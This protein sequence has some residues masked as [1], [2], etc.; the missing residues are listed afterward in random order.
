MP[1]KPCAKQTPPY[2]FPRWVLHPEPYGYNTPD[3]DEPYADQ[4][5]TIARFF[6]KEMCDELVASFG[7][8]AMD[9]TP[10]VKSR[11]YAARVNDRW[12][13]LDYA[14]AQGLWARLQP[15]LADL[16]VFHGA[17]G[18]NPNLRVYRYREGHWF[19]THYDESVKTRLREG[20]RE[21]RTKWTLLVYLTGGDELEGG[22]TVFYP[23]SSTRRQQEPIAFHPQRG[24]ALLHK[25]G[26]DCL[27][28][29]AEAVRRGFKW[30][31]RSDVAW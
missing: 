13:G 10:L 26:D 6:S 14:A 9:T 18:L 29:E 1:K 22:D 16:P 19:G 31:L 30:V 24:M 8:L 21:H 11:E 12:Q 4:I 28:H 15:L 23:P 17:A 5:V 20:G 27:A 3:V 25:H 2:A 7:S